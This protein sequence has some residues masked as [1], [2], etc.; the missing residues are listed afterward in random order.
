MAELMSTLCKKLF[1]KIWKKQPWVR[2]YSM[3]PGVSA[4]F[5]IYP[6]KQLN[7]K[8]RSWPDEPNVMS[9]KTC[10]GILKLTSTGWIIPAPA[11]FII[12]VDN[13]GI[14]YDWREPWRFKT[15]PE[16]PSDVARYVSAVH[17]PNQTVCLLDDPSE[18]LS[19]I[20]KIETPWRVE[21]ADDVVFI[22]MPVHYNNEDRFF[23]ATG[24]LDSRYG[25]NLNI[26]LFWKNQPGETLVRAGT[27]LCHIIPMKREYLGVGAYDVTIDDADSA[28]WVRER[29]WVY[30]SN[31]AI[32]AT[33]SLSA[34]LNRLSKIL[35]NYTKRK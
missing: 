5:P 25:Y 4:L 21:A 17:G 10:P 9:T 12:K 19:S 7:R 18:V 3:E 23:A 13:S 8:Y 34:R 30:A 14:S 20:V 32:M 35:K 16:Y 1:G 22:M 29:A 27:P 24:I 26:Q 6:S 33:D 11:D 15:G 28:D 2:F 31:C